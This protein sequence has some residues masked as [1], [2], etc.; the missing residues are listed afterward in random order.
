MKKKINLYVILCCFCKKHKG[1]DG[2]ETEKNFGGNP[3]DQS[4]GDSTSSVSFGGSQQ[5]F[6]GAEEEHPEGCECA[7]QEKEKNSQSVS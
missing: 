1:C 4:K 2:T 5:I 3:D 7:S 6:D